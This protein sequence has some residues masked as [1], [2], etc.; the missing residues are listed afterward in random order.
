MQMKGNEIFWERSITFHLHY[1]F[2]LHLKIMPRQH[3]MHD[4]SRFKC[5]ALHLHFMKWIAPRIFTFALFE[6][7][8]K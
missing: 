1:I 7:E 4:T 2:H 5:H 3:K 8:P 6:Y